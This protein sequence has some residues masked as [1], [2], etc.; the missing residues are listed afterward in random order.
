IAK[1]AGFA[2]QIRGQAVQQY[3]LLPPKYSENAIAS[4]GESI[5]VPFWP[6]IRPLV[7]HIFDVKTTGVLPMA[8]P[9]IAPPPPPLSTAQAT[10]TA[11]A[12]QTAVAS[13]TPGASG[14]VTA[15][16]TPDATTVAGSHT[17]TPVATRVPTR[18]AV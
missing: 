7:D 17:P 11:V 13:G 1:F 16:G 3:T 2:E 15:R 5:V 10:Q 8:V 6:E 12:H 4:D 9:K 18:T 14:T